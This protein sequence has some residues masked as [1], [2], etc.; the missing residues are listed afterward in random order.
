MTQ[1]V[2]ILFLLG[3]SGVGKTTLGQWVSEDLDLL[4]IEIDRFPDGDGID[5]ANLRTEWDAFWNVCDAGVIATTLR[6]RVLA[7]GACGAI[8]TFPSLVVFSAEHLECLEQAGIRVLVLY[9]AE[10][11]CLA[12]FLQR[13]R[14][15]GRNL[16]KEQWLHNNSH[17][18]KRLGESS[19][20][21]Y[22]LMAFEAGRFRSRATLV[23]A[24]R[25]HLG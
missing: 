5:L 16:S 22:R 8:L 20:E 7:K 2:P 1:N 13:E 19:Y 4:W 18:Q 24:V 23:G 10:E 9:G 25:K 17:I 15:S 12:A 14:E 11:T 6:E 21:R 3:P